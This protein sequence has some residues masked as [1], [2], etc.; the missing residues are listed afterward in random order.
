MFVSLA[1]L[2]TLRHTPHAVQHAGRDQVINLCNGDVHVAE[3]VIRGS[4]RSNPTT[5]S[6]LTLFG[7]WLMTES[8]GERYTTTADMRIRTRTQR[9]D[10]NAAR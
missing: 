1:L 8:D 7:M 9:V 6:V 5:D 2:K 10:F 4:V 3:L